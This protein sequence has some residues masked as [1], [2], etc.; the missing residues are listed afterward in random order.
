MRRI[1]RI[2]AALL[3]ILTLAVTA[4]AA[5]GASK[6]NSFATVS[7]DGSCQ[8]NMTVTFHME[9]AVD[10]L[11]FPVPREATGVT[12]NGSRVSAAR[13]GDIRRINL[14]RLVRGVVG[15]VIATIHYSLRDVIHTTEEGTLEMRVPMLSGFD[16]PVEAMEFSVTLPGQIEVLP[17]FVSGYHQARIEE[18]LVYQVEGA[19]VAGTSIRAMK[20]HE[21]LT[22]T[23]VVTEQMFPQNITQIQ[24]YDLG[25]NAIWVCV[26]LALLYWVIAMWNIPWRTQECTE[27]PEGLHAG[28]LG[29]IVAGQGT[30][31]SLLALSW[32]QLGYVT[33]RVDR[34][35]R[36]YLH[37][38]MEMGNERGEFE[39]RCFYKLFGKKTA[40][41]T[42]SL[43]YAQV[44]LLTAKRSEGMKELIRTRISNPK[45]FRTI[46]SGIG[47]FGGASLAVALA[48]GAALQGLLIF[49]LGI[50]G[51]VSG[52]F[53]QD[54]GAGLILRHRA[55]LT[56][57]LIP[58]A[59]WLLL[60]LF[61]G[62]FTLG[63]LMVFG[64]MIAGIL[65]S[66]GGRRTPLGKQVQ[67]Q[68]LGL[69]RYLRTVDKTQLQRICES[70]PDYF[71]RLAPSAL[72]LGADQ[73]FAKRF[74]K[75]K[76][77][78]CPYLVTE[79]DMPMSALQW[80]QVLRKT[81]HAMDERA[82]MLPL[83][84]LLALLQNM[85]RR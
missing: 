30:N 51:A 35:N 36:V 32:A 12:L 11:Y 10:R 6:M 17:A 9:Q 21:T 22:M 68:I 25:L 44:S 82:R 24:N 42:T 3:L 37:R 64:S 18:D 2:M 55:K 49:V 39:Q 41:D 63:A 1:R 69:R 46:A 7:S 8:V 78:R 57:S 45:V 38:R 4:E 47:L 48:N 56:A 34:K 80:S 62:A 52:W 50:A 58:A 53:M 33:I 61:A 29:S 84:K 65:L 72:A 28:Q 59:I 70:D 74:G 81:V 19:T 67:E 75:K 66:W 76:L 85:I 77:E 71:F 26:G 5:T 60:S 79:T 16:Y 23:M 14:S 27:A 54:F 20:D 73:A 43:H 31:L 13:S 83:E 15:D 40:V